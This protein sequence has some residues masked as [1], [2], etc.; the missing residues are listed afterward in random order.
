M[1]ISTV[2]KQQITA[3]KI[4]LHF[5]NYY[6]LKKI[7]SDY[8]LIQKQQTIPTMR[9]ACTNVCTYRSCYA[10]FDNIRSII[11]CVK[12]TAFNYFVQLSTCYKYLDRFSVYCH[13]HTRFYNTSLS[14]SLS[15]SLFLLSHVPKIYRTTKNIIT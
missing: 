9:K 5:Y 15:L 7:S 10:P 3:T 1:D 13:T 12:A 8:F 14:L 6:M 11:I 2:S 4:F